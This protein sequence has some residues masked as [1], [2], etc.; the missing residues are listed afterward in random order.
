ME[1]A[2]GLALL[3]IAVLGVSLFARRRREARLAFVRKYALPK[4]LDV[5]FLNRRPGL[6]PQQVDMVNNALRQYFKIALAANRK[7]VAMP[8]QAA[9]DLWHE[10]ILYTRNYQAFCDRAFGR[11]LHHTPAEA[12]KGAHTQSNAL[13]RAW[14]LACAQEGINPI[15]PHRLPMLFAIDGLLNIS[16]GFHYTPDCKADASR[17]GDVHCGA[18]LGSESGDG[19]SWGD[20]SSSGHDGDSGSGGGDGGGGGGC[21]GD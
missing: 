3:L 12:M 9:D 8:S 14:R 5:R 13:R 15:K 10:F 21:G 16:D 1:I 6:T 4:G 2:A 20:D 19:G 17:N 7:M 18:D 11:Y